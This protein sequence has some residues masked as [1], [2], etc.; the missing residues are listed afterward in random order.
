MTFWSHVKICRLRGLAARGLHEGPSEGAHGRVG[1]LA[2]I[3][4][5][6]GDRARRDLREH[7][8]ARRLPRRWASRRAE[9]SSRSRSPAPTAG[10]RLK[11]VNRRG[12]VVDSQRAGSLGGI[13][14]RHVTPGG[15]YRVRQR[16][17]G[18]SPALR[19]LTEPLGAAEHQAST[20]RRCPPG[21]YGY[22]STRDGTKL[23]IDVQLPGQR[24]RP[25][26]DA[27][28]VL[29]LRVREPGRRRELDRADRR[30]PRLRGRRR[31]HARHRLLGRGVRLLR[32]T[33]GARRLRRDRDRRP[34]AVGPPPQ[35][36]DD[37]RL[38]RR[39]QPA[40]RRRDAA[41]RPRRDRAAVGDRQHADDPLSG[42]DPEHGIRAPVGRGP[43]PRREAGVRHR[44]PA[45]GV[46]PDP[47]RRHDLQ[48]QPGPAPGGG[49]PDQEDPAQQLLPAQGRRPA[50]ADHLR[51]QDPRPVF[52]A[53]QWT[54]EQT[55]GHCPALPSHFTGTKRK[56]FT[57]TNGAHIDSLD[58]A[59]FNRWYDFLELYVAQAKAAADAGAEG[60]R[61][62][63]LPERD[64]RLRGQP[65]PD[66]IQ[67]QPNY[68]A[69]LAAFE[70]L[71]PVRILFDNGAGGSQPGAP[72]PGFE[73]SFSRFPVAGHAGAIVVPRRGRDAQVRQA[74]PR[75]APRSSPGTRPPGRRPTS[76][77]DTGSG[78]GGLW[79]ATPAYHWTQ[80]PAGHAV[81][82]MSRR[83]GSQ[84]DGDRRRR[85]PGVDPLVG[86]ERRPAGDGVRGATRRQGDLRPERLA[87]G[88][89]AQARPE[90]STPLEPV[91]SLR[92]SDAA[93]LPKD[94]WAK[95]T[96]PL[97]YQGHVY[98][99]GL[100]HPGDDRRARRRPAGLGLR[101]GQARRAPPAVA[102]A[103]SR[104]M[105]L[106]ASCCRSSRASTPP[107]A[108]PPCP[109]LRGEPCRNYKPFVNREV[110]VR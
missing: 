32:A 33:P 28:R 18:E 102:V 74:P 34:P 69:A 97:Y 87:A 81:S 92:K 27:D 15:G 43:R 23:A 10:Q 5:I 82:Y 31:Q 42:R 7:R 45:V 48:V 100:A 55:G 78:P 54:D 95:V 89:R 93:P 57:F 63:D 96:V 20:T 29:R 59:T 60:A 103:H 108:L 9:A 30:A 44:R 76:R 83:L 68:D 22:L 35:G 39:D 4:S 25:L 8:L 49:Q 3:S 72:S 107:P 105:P 77:G 21:G 73:R 2:V 6:G 66:P 86:A 104:Q 1:A 67:Q 12:E 99:S 101:R 65:A 37:G 79:T 106:R 61:A 109:G 64:G 24:R 16:G 88:Q 70:A 52:L 53:C 91:L 26:S 56:W 80:S 17:G 14:F 11:L 110:G 51:P 85:A 38:L 84:H 40:L 13:V 58:P 19:V 94:R 50:L 46:R 62:G 47:G 90:K 75:R 36:R 41:A 71:P 98:R